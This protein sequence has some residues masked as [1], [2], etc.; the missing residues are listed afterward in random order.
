MFGDRRPNKDERLNA[1]VA[2]GNSGNGE[3]VGEALVRGGGIV[4]DTGSSGDILNRFSGGDECIKR[5]V[6]P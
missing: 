1:S 4:C 3:E 6:E 5:R 2:L